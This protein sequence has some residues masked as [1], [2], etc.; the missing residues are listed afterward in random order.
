MRRM[1]TLGLGPDQE[2]YAI[3]MRAFSK[4]GAGSRVSP[5][6]VSLGGQPDVTVTE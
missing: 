2:T 1:E 3:I 4:V 5:V 6:R